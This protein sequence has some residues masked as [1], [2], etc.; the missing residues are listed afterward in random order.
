MLE[1]HQPKLNV[2]IHG[3]EDPALRTDDLTTEE[4]IL[5]RTHLS[6]YEKK[7]EGLMAEVGTLK[8]QVSSNLRTVCLASANACGRG[9]GPSTANLLR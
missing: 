2:S 9:L 1:V 5:L 7:I 3:E 8:N 4:D 6:A